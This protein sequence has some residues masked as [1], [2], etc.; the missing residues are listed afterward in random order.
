MRLL[1][2]MFVISKVDRFFQ[3]QHGNVVFNDSLDLLQL[4]AVVG[5]V[6]KVFHQRGELRSFPLGQVVFTCRQMVL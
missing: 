3:L 1:P 5:G 4:V 2:D 6:T